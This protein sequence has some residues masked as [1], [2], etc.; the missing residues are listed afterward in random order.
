[1]RSI[2][3]AQLAQ[4]GSR[5][6][7]RT[8]FIS[9]VHLG[10]A[11]SSAEALL[12]FLQ[13]LETETLYLV[14]DIF[15]LSCAMSSLA[16]PQAHH[17]VI[18]RVTVLAEQGTRV[19]YIPG[20]HDALLRGLEGTRCGKIE[21]RREA[22]HE[23]ADGRR[24]LVIHGDEF[25][26]KAPPWLEALGGRTYGVLL[27]LDRQL[28]ALGGAIGL[29]RYRIAATLKH[30][31]KAAM[32]VRKHFEH[33]VVTEARRRGVDGIICGHFHRAEISDLGGVLYCNDGDW[34]ES[35]TAL[36]EDAR[37]RL[38]LIEWREEREWALGA[39]GMAAVE[40]A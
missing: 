15:D 6:R 13:E 24:F 21:I 10:F 7:T 20:N 1:M 32:Q 14:G 18:R 2:P 11:G 8:T 29:R 33:A 25:D 39:E 4:A 12:S 16:W 5:R 17:D 27:G 22:V 38:S 37:G 28:N 31:A 36:S 3:A 30:A 26:S 19:V 40:A 9:D 23:T 35:R 34:V